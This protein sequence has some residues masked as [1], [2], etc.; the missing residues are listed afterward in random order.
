MPDDLELELVLAIQQSPKS[1]SDE[2]RNQFIRDWK[3]KAFKIVS[4]HS[5]KFL[6]KPTQEELSISLEALNEAINRF[7]INKYKNF[8]IFARRVILN[9]LVDYFRETELTKKE[10]I[11]YEDD[12]LTKVYDKKAVSDYA[13]SEIYQD[14]EQKRGEEI[15]KFKTIMSNLGYSFDDILKSQPKHSDSRGMIRQHAVNIVKS[16]LGD[17]LLKENPPSK[18]LIKLIGIDRRTLRKYRPY[19]FAWIVVILYDFPIIRS[20]LGLN[21]EG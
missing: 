8:E 2:L 14:L 1:R 16:G 15:R 9:K 13:S 17:R 19:L 21:R 11:T 5:K 10:Y 20:Y 7:D 18:D 12:T 3:D 6:R 4:N